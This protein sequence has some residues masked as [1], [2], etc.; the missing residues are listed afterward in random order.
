MPFVRKIHAN[1]I[2]CQSGLRFE[3][4]GV[5]TEQGILVSHLRYLAWFNIKSESWKERAVFSLRLLIEYI[6]ATP[7]YETATALLKG[8]SE[9][10]LTGTIDYTNYSDQS[11]L[12]WKPRNPRDTNNIL[13]HITNYT[14]FLAQQD[15]YGSS[16]INPF[17]KATKYEERMNWCSYYNKQQNVFLNHLSNSDNAKAHAARIRLIGAFPESVI[18]SDNVVRFPDE[19]IERLIY[20][21][22]D[23]AG[24]TDFRSQAITMLLNYGGLRKSEIFHIY[25]SDITQHPNRPSEALVRV[26]HPEYGTS[27]DDHYKNRSEYLRS[28]S[29][30]KP[31]TQY[32]SSERLH[33]GWKNPLLTSR[34]AFYEVVFSPPEKAKEFLATWVKYL[35]Y[36][37]V[38]PP[39]SMPHPFAFTNSYGHPETIKNFQRLHKNAVNRIGLECKKA[40]G[41]TE[42]G[43]RHAYGYRLRQYG[44]N[45]IEIQKAMHHKSP[46]SCLVYIKPTNE[47]VRDKMRETECPPLDQ[48]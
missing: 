29:Q 16:M 45:Q 26:Y 22:F 48:L 8:F 21:G 46:M 33:A 10:L 13:F 15:G 39:T 38:E 40:H 4:P 19:H 31:R 47:E 35:K 12:F 25:I 2:D 28:E 32:R 5:F 3:L 7:N 11:N 44:L 18:N 41:T 36:Q 34:E 37:R 20:L 24:T 43:H 14:D 27:P 9:K 30:Y 42:H 23:N 6:N 1:Y 17:R